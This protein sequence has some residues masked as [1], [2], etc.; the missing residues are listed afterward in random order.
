MLSLGHAHSLFHADCVTGGDFGENLHAPR[1]AGEGT[2]VVDG[3]DAPP[4]CPG[5]L[6]KDT[7]QVIAGGGWVAK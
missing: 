2:Q 3:E 5:F 7:S 6:I 1:S 4:A